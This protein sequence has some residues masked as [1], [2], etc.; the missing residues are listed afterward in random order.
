MSEAASEI[1]NVTYAGM[2]VNAAIAVQKTAEGVAGV[3][4]VH[5]CRARR[6][7]SAFHADLHVMVDHSLSLVAAHELSHKVKDAI[8]A[9]GLDVV[10]VIIHIEPLE[11]TDP[12][13]PQ[14][15]LP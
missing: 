4:E 8:L 6:Y 9:A 2:A 3:K 10:D 11:L 14:S 13:H 12:A 5:Q 7:G 1:R 15:P